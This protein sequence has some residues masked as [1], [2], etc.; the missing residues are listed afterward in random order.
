MNNSNECFK[1][2]LELYDLNNYI[3]KP[4]ATDLDVVFNSV[5]LFISVDGCMLSTIITK[6]NL[7]I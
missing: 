4:I 7:I 2:A 1:Q 3:L 6:G 5:C